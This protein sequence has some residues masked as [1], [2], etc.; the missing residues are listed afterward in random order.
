VGNY[1]ELEGL[2]AWIDRTARR[3]GFREQDYSTA[4]YARLYLEWCRKNGITP[5]NMVFGPTG[6]APPPDPLA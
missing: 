6:S 3:M 5:G 1:I 2:P 4:S